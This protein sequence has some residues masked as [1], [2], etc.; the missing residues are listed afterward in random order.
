MTAEHNIPISQ[1]EVP[2]GRR[3]LDPR[4]VE[5]LKGMIAEQG[6]M[7]AI[8]V[9]QLGE[10]K[11]RLVFGGH[12]LAAVAQLGNETIR[13][14]VKDAKTFASEAQL[15]LREIAE[16]L[17]RRELSVLDRAVDI[18]AWREIYEAAHGASKPGRKAAQR[19]D[20]DELELS[21]NF[22]LNFTEAAQQALN[23]SRRSVF[24]A[25]KVA[26]IAPDVRDRIALH[27]IADN[28]SDL[29]QLA[30]EPSNRQAQIANILLSEPALTSTVTGAIAIMD[31]VP[32]KPQVEGWEK[33]A[34]SFSGLKP[35]DQDRFFELHE[36][37]I[38][39]WLQ[40]RAGGDQN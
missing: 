6:Q 2:A 9:R 22:A 11:Y 18:A 36:A 16:N 31:R 17:I 20:A 40:N 32:A 33:L 24:L 29:L 13:S 35:K 7:Q 19:T 34:K 37:A 4:W 38:S 25:L 23:I 26:S 5:T 10:G 27:A 3:R 21:A 39:R 28:Q 15:R 12:R 1:I 30:A 14:Q 8:E